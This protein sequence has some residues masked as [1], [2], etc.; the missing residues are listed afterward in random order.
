M[1]ELMKNS[2]L[3]RFHEEANIELIAIEMELQ[4]G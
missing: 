3:T 2:H 1:S 4:F